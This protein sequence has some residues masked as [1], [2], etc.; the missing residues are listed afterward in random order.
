[1]FFECWSCVFTCHRSSRDYPDADVLHTRLDHHC[2]QKIG[3]HKLTMEVRVPMRHPSLPDHQIRIGKQGT[4]H[5]VIGNNIVA[6]GLSIGAVSRDEMF[7]RWIDDGHT[8]KQTNRGTS[9]PRRRFI[10]RPVQKNLI[11]MNPNSNYSNTRIRTHTHTHTNYRARGVQLALHA[12]R[13]D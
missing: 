7:P 12:A 11:L 13:A 3:I 2:S 4:L 5:G 6:G 10:S 8:D 1:M 9:D